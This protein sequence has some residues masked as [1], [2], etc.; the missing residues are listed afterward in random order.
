MDAA[1]YAKTLKDLIED[2]KAHKDVKLKA[3]D[4]VK[5]ILD[6]DN[7]PKSE[8]AIEKME[9]LRK[10]VLKK[11]EVSPKTGTDQ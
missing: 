11:Y 9:S 4:E 5:L 6:A 3:L 8:T 1:W 10:D 2:P 7:I